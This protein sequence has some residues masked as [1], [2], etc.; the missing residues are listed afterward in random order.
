M[1][2]HEAHKIPYPKVSGCVMAL[3]WSQ[4]LAGRTARIKPSTIREI[5]KLTQRSEV[6][7]FAGGLPAP[8]LFPVEKL[9]EAT[10]NVLE[11]QGSSALQYSTTEG[12]LPL[13]EWV[14][15]GLT[16]NAEQVQVVSGSQQGLDLVAKVLLDPGDKVIVTSPTY[17]GALRAFD[18]YE[19]EYLSVPVD[20][21][22]MIL[23]ELESALKQNPKLI[24]AIPNFD[25]P[26]GTT[27]SLKRRHKVVELA[28]RYGIPIYEDDPYGELRFEGEP[29]PSLYSLAPEHVIYAGTFSKIMVPGFRLG[30]LVAEP[31]LLTVIARAKQAA[32][33]HSST[34]TQ[35]IA[36]EVTKD[37]FMASQI[38]KVRKH[39]LTQRNAMLT[40]LEAYFPPE[41]TWTVPTG[42]MFLW[43]TL[44]EG[45]DTVKLLDKAVDQNVAYVPGGPFFATGGGDHTLRLSYSIA[46]LAEIDEGMKRLGSVLKEHMVTPQLA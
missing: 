29:L 14:A 37:G 10:A 1:L 11:Q 38:D 42:G 15:D 46:S 17:M 13:R 9:K 18:A 3:D 44:P 22:G 12:Y 33:L 41:V 30:W 39:Y 19:V 32:D 25:N 21:E 20:E 28:K 35:M 43:V 8:S 2:S 40:A 45:N 4:A 24:Y 34:F 6:V 5:L 23:E 16:V 27:L 26:T 31:D 36:H 7:S